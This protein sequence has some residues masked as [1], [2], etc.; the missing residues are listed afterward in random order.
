MFVALKSLASEENKIKFLQEAV[1]VGQFKHPNIVKLHGVV[2]TGKP[3]SY[4]YTNM[5]H[6]MGSPQTMMLL[7]ALQQFVCSKIAESEHMLPRL[8][9]F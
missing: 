8:L 9:L 3:V 6:T 4:S 7:V 2:T 1:I 5:T